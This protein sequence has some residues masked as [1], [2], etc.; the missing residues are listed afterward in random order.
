M[1]MSTETNSAGAVIP[2][3]LPSEDQHGYFSN[4]VVYNPQPTGLALW[5][6]CFPR[7]ALKLQIHTVVTLV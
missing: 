2:S 1:V 4:C 6:E 3:P 5:R 7:A